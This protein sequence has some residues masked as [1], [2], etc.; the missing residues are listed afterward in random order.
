[1]KLMSS[2]QTGDAEGDL[3]KKYSDA[4]R[5]HRI[6]TVRYG[7]SRLIFAILFG[8]ILIPVQAVIGAEQKPLV[9]MGSD[10]K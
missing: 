8:C 1:M 2:F 10:G 7:I 6:K 3:Q 4:N 5:N 9:Y